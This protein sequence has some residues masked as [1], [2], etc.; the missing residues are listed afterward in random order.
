MDFEKT[1]LDNLNDG[2]GL[3]IK[4]LLGAYNSPLN[5]MI[6]E[7]MDSHRETIKSKIDA[8]LSQDH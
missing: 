3:V 8:A 4:N 6:S 5:L 7:V 1:I 2:I